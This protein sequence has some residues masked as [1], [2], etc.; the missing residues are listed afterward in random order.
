MNVGN[1]IRR[2][3]EYRNLTQEYM[4]DRL[5]IGSTA[6]GNIERN[7]VKRLTVERLMQIA[8]VLDVH[9]TELFNDPPPQQ[10]QPKP[11]LQ[12]KDLQDLLA[13]F[14]QDKLLMKEMMTTMRDSMQ[15]M[16]QMMREHMR[17]MQ[18]VLH[19]IREV[20]TQKAKAQQP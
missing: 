8:E 19:P 15:K 6:Y 10:R 7:E 13:Y 1:T 9:F 3:R 2:L 14:R 5:C 18:A 20:S 11:V 16:D 12:E 4:A 17:I